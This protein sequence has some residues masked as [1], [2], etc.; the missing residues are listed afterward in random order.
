[1]AVHLRR[2]LPQTKDGF[3]ATCE[4]DHAAPASMQLMFNANSPTLIP[5]HSYEGCQMTY[6]ASLLPH[7][8]VGW[9]KVADRYKMPIYVFQTGDTYHAVS[10]EAQG[11]GRLVDTL[12]P[13]MLVSEQ[14]AY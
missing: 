9:Q 13:Q 8:L 3:S 1:V 6:P 5:L 12:A 7:L 14:V 4:P 10:N 2:C 11:V